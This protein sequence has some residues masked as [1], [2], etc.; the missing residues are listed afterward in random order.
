[1]FEQRIWPALAHGPMKARA[2]WVG[3]TLAAALE[4]AGFAVPLESLPS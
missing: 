3:G 1:M 2:N 4:A